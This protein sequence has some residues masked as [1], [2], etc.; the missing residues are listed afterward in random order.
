MKLSTIIAVTAVS[1][2][3]APTAFAQAP[4]PDPISGGTEVGGSVPSFLELIIAPPSATLASF[5]KAKTYSSAFNVSVT[6]TDGG[7]I[8]SLA[9]GDATSGK[10]LG[11]LASGS[12]RLPLPL[13]ARVGKSAFQPLD[14][15]VDPQMFKWSDA[16][17][18]APQTVNLRQQVKAKASGSYHK[19]LLV[20][21]STD[22]P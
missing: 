19:L 6:A 5:S 18:R 11:H 17:T 3:A 16:A 1:A 13:Q 10:K 4:P 22:T 12:K 2:L 20:T 15:T 21:A 9:D 14:Q 7:T 8:L